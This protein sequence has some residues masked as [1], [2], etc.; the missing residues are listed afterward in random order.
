MK[1]KIKHLMSCSQNIR[2]SDDVSLRVWYIPNS[3]N[4]NM[5]HSFCHTQYNIKDRIIHK[6][7]HESSISHYYWLWS[8]AQLDKFQLH[9]SSKV[10]LLKYLCC[11]Y[12]LKEMTRVRSAHCV[13]IYSVMM[14]MK[15]PPMVEHC[16]NSFICCAH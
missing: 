4:D 10:Y 5:C 2:N 15:H 9:S 14:S 7:Q 3:L 11:D 8:H 13:T 6:Y 1:L 16:Q 12:F